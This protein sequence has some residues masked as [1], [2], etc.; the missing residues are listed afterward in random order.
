MSKKMVVIMKVAQTLVCD[1]IVHSQT[2]VCAT[3][4]R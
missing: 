2:E 4:Q 3:Y 1:P